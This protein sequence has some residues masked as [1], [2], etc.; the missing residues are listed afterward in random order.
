LRYEIRPN[1]GSVVSDVLPIRGY[2]IILDA[3][4]IY[5]FVPQKCVFVVVINHCA[6]EMPVGKECFKGAEVIMHS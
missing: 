2:W 3:L 5:G 1:G 4:R 6:D